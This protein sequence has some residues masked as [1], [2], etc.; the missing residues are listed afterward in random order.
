MAKQTG[1]GDQLFVDGVD[2]AGDTQSIGGLTTPV[3]TL[4]MTGINKEAFERA[5]G[6]RE[7]TAEFTAFFNDAP[8]GTHATLSSLP[9]SNGQVMYLRG[10][11]QG[12][13]AFAMV[14]K[15]V[16]YAATRGDDG[17]LT[18]GVNAQSDGYGGDW[19]VQLTD[20]KQTDAAAT[21]SAGVD[22][23]ASASFGWQAYLQ[24]F[25]IGSG[26][27]TVS[28]E[29]SSDDGAVDTYADLA[30]FAAVTG[31]TTERLQSVSATATVERYVRVVTEGTF[32]DL[33]FAVIFNQNQG[34]RAI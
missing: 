32:T 19:C 13:A 34:L 31:K 25:S 27:A 28:I 15:R 18:F 20:G 12:R 14:G 23:G 10:A 2:I 5:Y 9:R 22:L 21:V 11:G 29:S 8:G 33:V 24:V 26:T 6:K 17:S 30:T 16:D 3:T 4:E 1:L 7:A